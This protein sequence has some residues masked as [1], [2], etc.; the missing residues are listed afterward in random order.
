LPAPLLP[1]SVTVGGVQAFVV[2]VGITPGLVGT[3]QLNFAV[4]PGVAAGT[5]PVVVTIAGV[6]SPAGN[7]TVTAQ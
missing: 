6:A 5:Q 4:P 3:A 2:F 1:V 7:I